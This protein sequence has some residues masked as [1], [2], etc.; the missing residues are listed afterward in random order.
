MAHEK[1]VQMDGYIKIKQDIMERPNG[2]LRDQIGYQN[3]LSFVQF[4]VS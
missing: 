3:C 1:R 4:S 2:D